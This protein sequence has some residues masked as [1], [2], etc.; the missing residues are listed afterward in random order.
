MKAAQPLAG[1]FGNLSLKNSCPG[2]QGCS[3]CAFRRW[4]GLCTKSEGGGGWRLLRVPPAPPGTLSPKSRWIRGSPR[5]S[6]QPEGSS[7][8][9]FQSLHVFLAKPGKTSHTSSTLLFWG[10]GTDSAQAELGFGGV[11]PPVSALCS[12]TRIFSPE[13]SKN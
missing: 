10:H 7:L 1:G 13:V 12:Q 3:R 5:R 8:V 4:L 11:S 2:T 6:P 9:L